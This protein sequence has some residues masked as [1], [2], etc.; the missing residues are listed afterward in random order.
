MQ[1][2]IQNREKPKSEHF[3]VFRAI[4]IGKDIEC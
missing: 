1:D 3:Y 2:N 4:N